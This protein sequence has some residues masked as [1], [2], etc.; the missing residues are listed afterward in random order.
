MPLSFLP[1]MRR[2]LRIRQTGGQLRSSGKDQEARN[3]EA[4]RS[5][6]QKALDNQL[7][8]WETPAVDWKGNRAEGS[9]DFSASPA[10][11]VEMT[12]GE[13]DTHTPEEKAIIEAYQKSVDPDMVDYIN[14]VS[15]LQDQSY[16]AKQIYEISSVETKQADDLKTI[17]G[18]DTNGYTNAI[19]GT[20]ITHI[21]NRHGTNGAADH[22][23]AN[24]EDIARIGYVLQNYDDI[25][26]LEDGDGNAIRST[27]WV[28][29]DKSHAVQVQYT[30]KIDGTYYV[31]EAVIDSKRK[32]NMVGSAYMNEKGSAAQSLNMEQSSPQL[33]PET[34][35]GSIASIHSI[36]Q[37][38]ETVKGEGQDV[39]RQQLEAGE[40]PSSV[41]FADTFPQGGRLSGG[42]VSPQ[43]QGAVSLPAG[44]RGGRRVKRHLREGQRGFC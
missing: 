31:I 16:K 1:W 34:P 10:A 13:T 44:H 14:R 17:T 7:G 32:Q 36:A 28:N 3:V 2:E 41:G 42:N 25:R 38:P 5:G 37:Q 21:E 43:G 8:D 19:N 18:I 15:K 39:L 29:S 11:P 27:E 40:S 12:E 35:N 9:T 20:T 30:K 26:L 4:Y 23:M 6:L 24:V 22:S 33:T